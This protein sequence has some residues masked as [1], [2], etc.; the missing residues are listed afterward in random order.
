MRQSIVHIALVVKDYDE[1]IDFYVSK[2]HFEL[3]E[4][5]LITLNSNQTG[6]PATTLTAGIDVERGDENNYRFL[7][8]ELTDTFKIG[9]VGSLQAVATRE[10]TPT[11]GGV[12]TW[13]DTTKKFVTSNFTLDSSGL[14]V[15]SK[16]VVTVT[17]GTAMP[18]S[19][20][21]GDMTYREDLDEL[22][23]YQGATWIQI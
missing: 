1:A 6:T 10:D 16:K 20:T 21:L 2:L 14:T 3:I 23:F 19:P 12:A 22:Y 17:S 4:D 9:M 7:F 13:D 15:Q 18:G 11:A 5:N 8:E